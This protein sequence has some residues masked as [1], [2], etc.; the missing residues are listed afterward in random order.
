MGRGE[1]SIFWYWEI[2]YK[3]QYYR[4]FHAIDLVEGEKRFQGENFELWLDD[5]DSGSEED[6][7]D[8][9]QGTNQDRDKGKGGGRHAGRR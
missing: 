4:D 6:E 1:N 7:E 3:L 8:G 9:A 2:N 5:F